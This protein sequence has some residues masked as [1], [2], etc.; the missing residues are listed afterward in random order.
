[1]LVKIADI[2]ITKN[3]KIYVLSST[4]KEYRGTVKKKLKDSIEI[5][6]A[7]IP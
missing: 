2:N 7:A 3:V 6:E 4:L 1:V 5:T